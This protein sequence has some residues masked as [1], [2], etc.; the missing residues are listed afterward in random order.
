MCIINIHINTNEKGGGKMTKAK[1]E[2]IL[3]KKGFQ[4]RH[5]GRHDIWEKKGYLPIPVARHKGDIP[6]GT[7]SKILKLIQ[8]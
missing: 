1:L 8:D 4:V 6:K 2:K 3:R 5:G 7:L